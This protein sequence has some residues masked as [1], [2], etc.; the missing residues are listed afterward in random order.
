MGRLLD[1]LGGNLADVGGAGGR[2][3]PRDGDRLLPAARVTLHERPVGQPVS[4]DNVQQ[5]AQQREVGAG[6]HRQV[7]VRALGGGRAA[8]VGAD[9]ERAFGLTVADARPEDR[10]AGGRVRPQQQQ[11][12]GVGDVGV[13]RRRAVE[14][15]RAAVARHR[16]RHAQA[17][18]RIDVVRSQIAL[19]ELVDRVVVLRQQ[20]PGDV[21]GDRV[22]AVLVDDRPQPARQRAEHVVPAGRLEARVAILAPQRAR[23]A[24]R[25]VH[26]ERQAKR[27]T[28]GAAAVGGMKRV[29]AHGLEA[30]VVVDIGQ[31]AAA[32]AAV[33]ALGRGGLHVAS[34]LRTG[35]FPG[36]SFR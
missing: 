27:L 10:V 32:D 9:D 11:A 1:E 24:V 19:G 25:R 22:G 21:E 18:V 7:Q 26:G 5:G 3:L 12:V 4:V 31:Q 20:L 34:S 36:A 15:E 33:R 35:R 17:G 29:A 16:R 13:A 6:S 28:A 8:R 30:A 23:R 2:P 14:A